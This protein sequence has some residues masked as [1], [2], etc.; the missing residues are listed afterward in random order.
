MMLSS[1]HYLCGSP[2]AEKFSGRQAL[3][4]N[5]SDVFAGTSAKKA[6]GVTENK[7]VFFRDSCSNA[8]GVSCRVSNDNSPL[9]TRN[10]HHRKRK[11]TEWEI[12]ILT[13]LPGRS[14]RNGERFFGII[15][16]F[17]SPIFFIPFNQPGKW[18]CIADPVQGRMDFSNFPDQV[19]HKLLRVS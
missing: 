15:F 14:F 3:P 19:G 12:G 6:G 17:S 8:G 18:S 13:L 5:R 7:R 16:V 11:G 9:N 4:E 1:V 2:G 10:S